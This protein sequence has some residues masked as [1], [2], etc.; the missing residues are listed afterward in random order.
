[1]GFAIGILPQ[2]GGSKQRS[3]RKKKKKR[4]RRRRRRRHLQS[5]R[6]SEQHERE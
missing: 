2:N 5:I 6:V 4:R 1:M 3:R